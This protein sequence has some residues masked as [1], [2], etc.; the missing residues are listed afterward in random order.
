MATDFLSIFVFLLPDTVVNSVLFPDEVFILWTK[1]LR[2]KEVA[3]IPWLS[4]AWNS[5]ICLT[6]LTIRF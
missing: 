5:V 1:T 2:H 3:A 4:Q 6:A